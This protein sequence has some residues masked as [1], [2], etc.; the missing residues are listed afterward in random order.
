MSKKLSITVSALVF[1]A[2]IGII[3]LI[4]FAKP[5]TERTASFNYRGASAA[6]TISDTG[7]NIHGSGDLSKADMDKQEK[8]SVVLKNGTSIDDTKLSDCMIGTT[9]A[10]DMDDF[11]YNYIVDSIDPAQVDHIVFD[12]VRVDIE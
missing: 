8:L 1:L 3:C 5:S 9:E 11:D 12:G 4:I 6:V 10:H 7:I 2:V